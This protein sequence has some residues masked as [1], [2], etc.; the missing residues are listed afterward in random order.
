[1]MNGDSVVEFE[2]RGRQ[3]HDRKE[4]RIMGYESR[5]QKPCRCG[6]IRRGILVTTATPAG[7]RRRQFAMTLALI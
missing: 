2:R 7:M 4:G 5:R 3:R 6:Q 1:M